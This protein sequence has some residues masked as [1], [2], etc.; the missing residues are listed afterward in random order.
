MYVCDFLSKIEIIFEEYL[1]LNQ[2]GRIMG[3][4]TLNSI[5]CFCLFFTVEFFLKNR[6]QLNI[7]QAEVLVKI[8]N[9]LESG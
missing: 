8:A 9:L 6:R 4:L 1:V 5:E 2:L 7:K 3:Y